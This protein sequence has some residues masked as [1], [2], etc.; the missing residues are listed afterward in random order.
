MV[1]T[2][3]VKSITYNDILPSIVDFVNNSNIFTARVTSNPK[4]WKGV[5]EQQPITI[6]NSTTG[7]SFDGLD[8]FDTSATNNTRLM[9][10]QS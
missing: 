10:H 9:N 1:F 8:E 7:G 5:T 6:A 3:R 4:N 2:D